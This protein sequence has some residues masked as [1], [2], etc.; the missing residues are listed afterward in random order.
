MLDL[1]TTLFYLFL[2][3]LPLF[4]GCL[5]IENPY[6]KLAPG[7]WRGVLQVDPAQASVIGG[8]SDQQKE[9][10]VAF[11]EV[12]EGELPFEF[13]VVYDTPDSFHI[14]LIN[15]EER[16]V[17]RDILFGLDRR[18]AK[19]T[20]TV[21]FPIYDTYLEA[22][23]ESGVMQGFWIVNYKEEYRIPFVAKYGEGYRFTQ[24]TKEPLLDLSGQWSVQFEPNTPEAYPAVAEFQQTG[25][26]LTGTFRTETGD[27]RF[28]AGTVQANKLYLSCFDGAHAFLFEGKINEDGTLIGSFRSGKHYLAYWEA[29]RNT[30]AQMTDPDVLT[31][32]LNPEAPV[33]IAFTDA[34]GQLFSSDEPAYAGKP[35]I[36]QIMG[37]WCPNCLDET[38]FLKEYLA[39]H[40]DFDIPIISITFEKYREQEKVLALL[41]RYR[42]RLNI[43]WRIVWGGFANKEEAAAA[44]PFLD[45]IKAYPTLVFLDSEHRI[46][47]VHT[48][49]DGPATSKYKQFAIDFHNFVNPLTGEPH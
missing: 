49:F 25:N 10:E 21:S 48:G 16:I 28:L 18:T 15:G 8:R 39:E 43:P 31:G 36:L 7:M 46:R 44:L 19:D 3:A 5:V 34:D 14:V 23:C 37:T 47:R 35:M 22:V 11:E 30:D 12:T 6:P 42:E 9:R 26:T 32:V 17:S 27:Y 13:E 24:L 29:Q 20:L 45:G 2:M 38:R 4:S 41:K 33:S 1:R 40:P